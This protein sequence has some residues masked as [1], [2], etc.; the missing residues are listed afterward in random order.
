[1]GAATDMGTAHTGYRRHGYGQGYYGQGYYGQGYGQGYGHDYSQD[2]ATAI[3][4]VLL[5]R[6]PATGAAR[7][8]P[9]SASRDRATMT[10]APRLAAGSAATTTIGAVPGQGGGANIAA[11]IRHHESAANIT[12]PSLAAGS[13]AARSAFSRSSQCSVSH[14][15]ARPGTRPTR[16]A[17]RISSRPFH[18]RRHGGE[19]QLDVAAG[20]EAES[21]RDRKA[22]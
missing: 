1:M 14:Y 17:H 18:A 13:A 9:R 2:M 10:T 8:M 11:P 22:G 12:A 15:S 3:I 4:R 19:D 7:S 16:R 20:L 21:C 5:H 6:L